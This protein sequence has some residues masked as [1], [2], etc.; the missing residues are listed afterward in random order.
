VILAALIFWMLV[1]RRR[2][3]A[4]LYADL[5]PRSD[6][7]MHAVGGPLVGMP[8]ETIGMPSSEA[9]LPIT[10][11]VSA[12]ALRPPRAP[13]AVRVNSVDAAATVVPGDPR[14]VPAEQRSS[15]MPEL[16]SE[17]KVAAGLSWAGQRPQRLI[18]AFFGTGRDASSTVPA[19][20]T[21]PGEG[22]PAAQ[23]IATEELLRELDAR[24][25]LPGT[26]EP[27]PAYEEISGR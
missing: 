13:G 1:R 15:G 3:R 8:P 6:D 25:M 16:Q 18:P 26:Q 4:A 10:P 9:T 23:A 5:A 17:E 12:P 24:G 27:L 22:R 14:K 19:G 11:Y 20:D 2:R 21:S 7:N